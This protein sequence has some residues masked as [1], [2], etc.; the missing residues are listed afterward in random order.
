MGNNGYSFIGNLIRVL[1]DYH[2]AEPPGLDDKCAICIH[3]DFLFLNF[4]GIEFMWLTVTVVRTIG[5]S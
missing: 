1:G 2:A 3:G 5:V 4:H